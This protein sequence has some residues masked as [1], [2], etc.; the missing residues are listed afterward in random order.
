[1]TAT[2][3]AL[4][5]AA[6]RIQ[7]AGFPSAFTDAR[8]LLAHIL[9]VNP[10]LVLMKRDLSAEQTAQ[11]G[12]AVSRRLYGEPVQ[13]ITGCAPFRYT[14]VTVGPG[15]FI[16]RPETELLVDHALRFLAGRPPRERV[17]VELCA[18]SG[19]I[20]RSLCDEIAGVEGHAVEISSDAVAYL[21]RNVADRD[22]RVYHQDMAEAL[23]RVD[24]RVDLVVVN[25]PYVPER[26]KEDLPR[27]V[28]N[29]PEMALFA[30]DDGL[31]AIPV[32]VDAARRL[33]KPGGLVIC[34]HDESHAEQVA[35]IFASSAFEG[36]K[37]H[38]DLTH[39]PRFVTALRTD[40]AG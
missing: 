13:H 32:V 21:R 2:W 30:G 27:D 3:D 24:G 26:V 33:L 12:A 29:D 31:D 14:E 10:G 4:N 19:A 25:P 22:V 36:V 39:R 1:M 35:E 18:G 20:I 23:P 5:R 15:V 38:E 34:E 17:V 9:G 7:Q 40:V 28:R 37:T 6:E 11:F 8:I 16:P